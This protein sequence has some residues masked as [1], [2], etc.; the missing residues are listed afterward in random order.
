MNYA[1]YRTYHTL[2]HHLWTKSVGAFDYQKRDWQ[3]LENAVNDIAQNGLGDPAPV[4]IARSYGEDRTVS[5]GP[6]YLQLVTFPPI[7]MPSMGGQ[8]IEILPR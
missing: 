3:A 1:R 6:A 2:L 7:S 5:L 4:P 8:D